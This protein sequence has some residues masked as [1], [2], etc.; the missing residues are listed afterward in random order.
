MDKE[1][2]LQRDEQLFDKETYE[3]KFGPSSTTGKRKVSSDNV[4]EMLI[5]IEMA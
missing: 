3:E 4:Y 5:W 2:V 1:V